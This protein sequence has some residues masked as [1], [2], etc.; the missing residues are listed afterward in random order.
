MQMEEHCGLQGGASLPVF[1]VRPVELIGAVHAV[2]DEP[3]RAGCDS[4]VNPAK[5]VFQ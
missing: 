1:N 4:R 3:G 2:Q 5:L